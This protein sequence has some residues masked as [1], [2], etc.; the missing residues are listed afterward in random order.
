MDINLERMQFEFQILQAQKHHQLRS[1][2]PPH[3][4]FCNWAPV[5]PFPPFTLMDHK[6]KPMLPVRIPPH[7]LTSEGDVQQIL[8]GICE[9]YKRR[10][11]YPTPFHCCARD[12]VTLGF[13]G[14]SP[15]GAIE[16]P[17]K[18]N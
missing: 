3:D 12:E 9:D 18:S 1:C 10:N 6:P 14:P 4:F 7:N 16:R 11:M 13:R 5:L 8:C 2:I 17:R 15:A